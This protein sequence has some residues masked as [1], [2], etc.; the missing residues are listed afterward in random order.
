MSLFLLE[1]SL[2]ELWEDASEEEICQAAIFLAK[3]ILIIET[4]NPNRKICQITWKLM[5]AWRSKRSLSIYYIFDSDKYSFVG[6][7]FLEDVW[8]IT[9]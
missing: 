6:G 3:K 8:K 4:E 7:T 9:R 5:Q 1:L 2:I